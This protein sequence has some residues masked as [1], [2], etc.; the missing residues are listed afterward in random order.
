MKIN[1]API[2][3]I[4]RVIGGLAVFSLLFTLETNYRYLGLFGIIPLITGTTG[5]CPLYTVLGTST[6]RKKG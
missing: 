3:R 5:V 6:L 4:L 1:E 2:E